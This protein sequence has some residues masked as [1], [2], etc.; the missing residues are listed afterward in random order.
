MPHR[1]LHHEG[2]ILSHPFKDLFDS[3]ER[4]REILMEGRQ[5]DQSYFN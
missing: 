5:Q 1:Y 2:F 4:M 3:L